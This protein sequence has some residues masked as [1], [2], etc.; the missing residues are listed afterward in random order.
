LALEIAKRWNG[1]IVSVDSAK[2]YRGLN[3]GTSKPSAHE[4]STVPHHLVDIMDPKEECSSG[5]FMELAKHALQDIVSRQKL[6]IVL[7][8]TGFYLKWLMYGRDGGA[9]PVKDKGK[10][11]RLTEEVEADAPAK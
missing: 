1:E 9:P 4:L 3:I 10:L 8:G 11:K 5:R 6:P 2:V 7:A